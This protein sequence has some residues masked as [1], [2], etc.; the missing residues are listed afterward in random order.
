[1]I[2]GIAVIEDV[3][4]AFYLALL[5]PVLG[6]AQSAKDAVIGIATAFAFLLALGVVA[7]YGTKFVSKLIGTQD[8]EIV[9]VVFVG[10]AMTVAGIAEYLGVSDA[11]GAFMVVRRC[12]GVLRR[13][14]LGLEVSSERRY[15][16]V[17][18]DPKQGGRAEPAWLLAINVRDH[19]E[20]PDA[21]RP[22]CGR[23]RAGGG[24]PLPACA[25][26]TDA[27]PPHGR[28]FNTA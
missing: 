27:A 10:L 4:L 21:A 25:D 2:L 20:A 11:I 13:R 12:R 28:G 17:V 7:R 3:F 24:S 8:E 16:P 9:V 22:R 6:G 15:A 23:Q 14:C 5:Q 26:A 18:Q 19:D 1:V